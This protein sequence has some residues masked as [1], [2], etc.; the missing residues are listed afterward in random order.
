MEP[1]FHQSG[2]FGCNQRETFPPSGPFLHTEAFTFRD[3]WLKSTAHHKPLFVILTGQRGCSELPVSA[4]CNLPGTPAR[5]HE[6]VKKT[7]LCFWSYFKLRKPQWKNGRV[8]QGVDTALYRA[9]QGQ[10]FWSGGCKNSVQPMPPEI[11]GFFDTLVNIIIGRAAIKSV[12]SLWHGSIFTWEVLNSLAR[13]AGGQRFKR[14]KKQQLKNKWH[15]S[16]ES[17]TSNPEIRW[18]AAP[19]RSVP[20]KLWQI[21]FCEG[22]TPEK[23]LELFFHCRICFTPSDS[24]FHWGCLAVPK[25]YISFYCKREH[26]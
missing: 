26:G 19:G 15:K 9:L 3:L 20:Y 14:K 4:W 16:L 5:S 22:Q 23:S 1:N 6:N 2:L 11:A 17:I 25:H 18:R 12:F 13:K 21:V 7:Q 10:I 8:W 24:C